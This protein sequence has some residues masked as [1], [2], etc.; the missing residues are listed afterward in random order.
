MK[1]LTLGSLLCLLLLAP[2][3]TLAQGPTETPTETPEPS[4]TPIIEL[5][6]EAATTTATPTNT[7]DFFMVYDLGEGHAGRLEY[8]VTAGELMIIGLL[9]PM[10]MLL[11]FSVYLGLRSKNAGK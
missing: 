11:A 6:T 7:P 4:A 2:L 1:W 10:M 8:R 3:P 5:P 9:V